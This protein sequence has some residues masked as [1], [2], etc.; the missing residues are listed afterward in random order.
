MKNTEPNRSFTGLSTFSI[1][2]AITVPAKIEPMTKAP[3][4]SEKP[5]I[6]LK[7]AI[8]KHNPIETTSSDSLLRNARDRL[9]NDG[10][11]YTPTINQIIRKN[12]SLPMLKS[13]SDPF[14][15]PM[16]SEERR[17]SISTANRSSIISTESTRPANFFCFNPKSSS[18]FMII[19]VEDIEIIPPKKIQFMVLKCSRHPTPKPA[20]VIPVMMIRAV[21]TADEPEFISLRK[22]N[23]R[24][25]VN[26]STTIPKS[27]Q[28]LMFS[29]LDMEG[30]YSK[31]GLARNPARI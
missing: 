11:R 19:V 22:L 15:S 10:S 12:T 17:T 5:H 4:S 2:S 18:D 14:T 26:I 25:I 23:S 28:N 31:L 8:E 6:T 1:R 3:N 27:A 30:R 24:P 7:I 13:N 20:N 21:T 16:A 9:R 29:R